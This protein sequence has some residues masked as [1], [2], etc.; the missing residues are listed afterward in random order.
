[1]KDRLIFIGVNFFSNITR[2]YGRYA[3][4]IYVR[5]KNQ[6]LAISHGVFF[7]FSLS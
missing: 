3:G 5:D 1:M 2:S 7:V 4:V 6:N